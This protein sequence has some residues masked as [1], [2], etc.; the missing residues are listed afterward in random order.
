MI[1]ITYHNDIIPVHPKGDLSW[2]FTGRTDAG[3]KTPIVWPP[4]AKS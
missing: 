2:V 4:H 3:A 1:N